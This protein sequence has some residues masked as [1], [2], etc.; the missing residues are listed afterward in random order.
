[1]TMTK[2]RCVIIGASPDTDAEIIR[3]NICPDDFVVCADGGRLFAE[4]ADIMPD[5]IIGDFDSSDIPER[6]GCERIILPVK[7][8]DTDTLYCIKE[9]IKRGYTE[10]LLLGM[11]GGR[12]D[13]TFANYSVLLYLSARGMKGSIIGPEGVCGMISDSSINIEG[14]KGCGF[15][16]FPFGCERCRVTLR[17]FLY[18]IEDTVLTAGYPIGVS[19]EITSDSAFAEVH[20]G[21]ALFFVYK[22]K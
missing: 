12:A 18:E 1:M 7:K 19:N 13:H 3:E 21:N 10:F 9:C 2:R 20:D 5:L 4:A 16:I 6:S 14:K 11:T 15:G 17:G 22:N 8:D